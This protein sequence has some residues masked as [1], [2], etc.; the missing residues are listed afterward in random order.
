VFD[1][2]FVRRTETE[3]GY[4]RLAIE[5]IQAAGIRNEEVRDSGKFCLREGAQQGIEVFCPEADLGAGKIFEVIGQKKG[6]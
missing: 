2:V 4:D 3:G 5:E 6:A 1:I